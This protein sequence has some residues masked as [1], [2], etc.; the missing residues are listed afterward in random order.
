M[1][2]DF[3]TIMDRRGHDALAV[4]SIGKISFGPSAPDPGFTAIPMWVADMNFPALPAIQEAIIKRV[5]HP[6][7][8]Y[9]EVS[10]AYYDAIINWQKS[11]NGVTGLTKEAIGYENGVLGGVISALNVLCSRGDSVLLHSPTY[12]GFT[13]SLTSNGYRIVHSPLKR[14]ENGVWRMDFADM[15]AKIK[16]NN[17]HAAVFCSPHNPCGRVWERWE[18]EEAYRIFEKYDVTVIS[19]EFWSDIILSGHRHISS[20]SVNDY[21]KMNTISLYAPSKT[22]NLAGLIGS[23]H[24]IYD[25]RLRDR[26]LKESSLSHYNSMNVLSMHALIGAYTD[27]GQLWVDELREVLTQNVDFAVDFIRTNF[28]GVTVQ[29]PEGTYMLFVDC[30]EWLKTHGKTLRE[31]EEMCWRVGVALQ[32]GAMFGGPTSVRINLALPLSRVEEAMERLKK[33]VF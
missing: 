1:K 5:Q 14:D 24:I 26:V 28:E 13:F 31:L 15:E 29:K 25:K 8:G 16:K 10:D 12:I 11:R 2:Y 21:A 17:I 23:Y 9:F 27:E 33:Y 6:A 32:D 18:L 4:D 30:G 20:Q 3:T 7:F 19:D 22:F